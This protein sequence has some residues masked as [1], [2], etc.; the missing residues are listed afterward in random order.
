MKKSTKGIIAGA[1][2]FLVILMAVFAFCLFKLFTYTKEPVAFDDFERYALEQGYEFEDRS[3]Q[4]PEGFGK[5]GMASNGDGEQEILIFFSEYTEEK[6]AKKAFKEGQFQ[7]EEEYKGN[8]SSH[9]TVNLKNFSKYEQKSGGYFAVVCRVDSTVLYSVVPD[10]N[11]SELKE[12]IKG[13]G[14]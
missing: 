2:I 1:V 13:L 3:G 10:E 12:F 7:I 6:D 14:Y 4:M 9:K 5:Y 8:V 11:G